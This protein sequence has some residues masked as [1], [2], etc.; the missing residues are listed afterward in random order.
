MTRDS[1]SWLSLLGMGA[2]TALLLVAGLA[3]G[4]VADR[5]L[6]TLPIFTLIGLVIGV[7]SAATYTYVEFHR[8][9]K[10]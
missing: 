7:G 10:D 8:F 6:H 9:Y 4:W 3:A 1:P 2:A 5:F